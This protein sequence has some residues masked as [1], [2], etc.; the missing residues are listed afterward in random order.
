MFGTKGVN[1]KPLTYKTI[2]N[3][4]SEYDLWSHYAGIEVVLG[5]KIV[6]PVREELNPS[7][8]FFV[9]T[10]GNLILKD[11]G[12]ESWSIWKYLKWKYNLDYKGIL[13]MIDKDYQ[14]GFKSINR[15]NNY[16]TTKPK[17]VITNRK[18]EGE[19]SYIYPA[20]RDFTQEDLEYW[21]QYGIT[22]GTLKKFNVSSLTCFWV[23]KG[24]K[25]NNHVTKPGEFAF[26]YTLGKDKYKIYRPLATNYKWVNNGSSKI[27]LG[28]DN[29][30]WVGDKLI[31]TKSL[32]DVMLLY[33]LGI[34]SVALQSE[35]TFLDKELYERLSKRFKEI[36]L[37]FDN[38]KTGRENSSKLCA[39]YKLKEIFVQGSQ[40]DLSDYC[41]VYGVDIT[42][43]ELLKWLVETEQQDITGK[44]K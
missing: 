6:S 2:L 31:I 26:C 3:Y 43:T 20:K 9:T 37:L 21:K 7:A 17:P 39:A 35:N 12:G 27:L 10:E 41:K 44:E 30:P 11:F 40:K 1:T 22:E 29:L 8:A 16:N 18:L 23:V 19:S 38:D 15:V 28:E 25:A 24:E 42:K 14:L 34:P 36:Y 32:K 4:V 13:E 5:K 33:E